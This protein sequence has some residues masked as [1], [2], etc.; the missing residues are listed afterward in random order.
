M[1]NWYVLLKRFFA[2]GVFTVLVVYALFGHIP[3][4]HSMTASLLLPQTN[5]SAKKIVCLD[6]GHG[7]MDPGKVGINKALEKDINLQIVEKLRTF[8]LAADV[9]VI[10]TRDCD[11]GLYDDNERNKKVQDMKNRVRKI[12]ECSPDLVVSIH[13][14]SYHDENIHGAQIFF[15]KSSSSSEQAAVLLQNQLRTHVDADNHRVP[16]ANDS[17]YLLKKTS[18]PIVIA[19]CGFLSNRTEAALLVD[20]AYQE[21]IAWALHLGILQYLNSHDT[22]AGS[23]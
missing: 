23:L 10:L 18:A 8:L 12:E 19:E 6:A 3:P 17:Y 7:G 21:K 15:Y 5:A 14:N 2:I 11:H 9:E 22:M 1:G 13:Q 20:E 16:K 4:T